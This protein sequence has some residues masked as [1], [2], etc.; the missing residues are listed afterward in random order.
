[1]KSYWMGVNDGV[2]QV[3]LKDCPSPKPDTGQILIRMR[4]AG[5]NRG[6]FLL[7]HGLHK[8]G[9]PKPIGIEAAGEVIS[10]GPGVSSFKPGDQVLGRCQG[11]FSDEVLLSEMEAMHKPSTLSWEQ[12]G[13]LALTG[14]TAHDCLVIQGGLK[15]GEWVFIA[16]VSSGVGVS[17]L[18]M[19]KALGARVIGTSGS[20]QKLAKLK[21]LGLD[22]GLCMRGPG[23]FD[24]VMQATDHKG[25]DLIVN[26]VGGTVFE[27]CIRILGFQ[28]RLATV[29][30]VDDVVSSTID[31]K[32]LHARRL[33]LFGVSNKQRTADQKAEFVPNF[34]HQ[35]L[36]LVQE[37]KVLPLV[38]HVFAFEDLPQAIEMMQ[39]GDHVGKIILSGRA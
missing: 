8:A 38:D 25:V 18:T 37:G 34:R 20:E 17:A 30:Y 36:P 4:A 9:P 11:G 15:P 7:K 2:A 10:V 14:L 12:A 23:F 6:E 27:E 21:T 32:T 28:G 1:M 3:E 16:G 35:I 24:A 5:L 33:R 29:G 31:L 39:A 22:V 13:G 19:A 26:T